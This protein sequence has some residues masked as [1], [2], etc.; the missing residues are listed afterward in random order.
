MHIVIVAVALVA[1]LVLAPVPVLVGVLAGRYVASLVKRRKFVRLLSAPDC[2]DFLTL[3]VLG[4]KMTVD[5]DLRRLA[6]HLQPG[7]SAMLPPLL[8]IVAT[9]AF[10][11]FVPLAPLW[12]AWLVAPIFDI[13]V[14][15]S[16]NTFVA[17][18]CG[19]PVVAI[20]SADAMKT[21][22]Q[23]ADMRRLV[24][25]ALE[26]LQTSAGTEVAEVLSHA[27]E[28]NSFYERMTR[29]RDVLSIAL[30]LKAA[31]ARWVSES[32]TQGKPDPQAVFGD[33]VGAARHMCRKL[34]EAD[35]AYLDAMSNYHRARTAIEPLDSIRLRDRVDACFEGLQSEALA[36]CLLDERWDEYIEIVKSISE[37]LRAAHRD[38][39]E[40][41]QEEAFGRANARENA[42]KSSQRDRPSG[43]MDRE[44]ALKVLNLEQ[45]ATAAEVKANYRLLVQ[46]YHSD[47]HAG[48]DDRVR[49]I[50]EKFM[51]KLNEAYATLKKEMQL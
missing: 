34:G 23:C 5:I 41:Q 45:D 27:V 19:L 40:R 20:A 15:P 22:R 28:V 1:V 10:V 26:S 18:L 7:R 51:Q 17:V 32:A 43:V 29:K 47:R 24:Q 35:A 36:G 50:S 16:V 30:R 4:T 31:A 21:E 44:E 25:P 49:S 33:I 6:T 48:A 2:G 8:G 38:A 9:V 14:D 11:W 13:Q 46:I 3:S 12:N 42:K 39:E 37:D